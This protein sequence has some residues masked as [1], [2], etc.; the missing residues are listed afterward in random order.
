MEICDYTYKD[1]SGHRN[2]NNRFP[3][4]PSMTKKYQFTSHFNTN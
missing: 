3:Q 2:S 4:F 1:F